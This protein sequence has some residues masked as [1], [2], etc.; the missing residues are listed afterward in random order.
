MSGKSHAAGVIPP[1]LLVQLYEAGDLDTYVSRVLSLLPQ[2]V[3]SEVTS[4]NEVNPGRGRVIWKVEPPGAEF[5]EARDVFTA[6]MAKHPL[7][8]HYYRTGD[9]RVLKLSDFVS[10]RQLRSLGIYQDCYRLIGVD[11]Q[12]AVTVPGPRSLVVG[13][14]VNR[15]GRDFSQAD[16]AVLTQ[17]RPHLVRA[18][19]NTAM[20]VSLRSQ[21]RARSVA[22]DALEEGLA[23]VDRQGRLAYLNPPARE[24]LLRIAAA[25]AQSRSLPRELCRLVEQ[26]PSRPGPSLCGPGGALEVRVLPG[27]GEKDTVV[28]LRGPSAGTG[29]LVARAKEMGLTPGRRRS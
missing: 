20:F 15:G 24:L 5:P 4:Y 17:L 1:E 6:H 11:R 26:L 29:V 10:L 19:A 12:L 7:I 28:V 21:L 9:S 14:T 3:G 22:L 18:Y 23:V 27:G 2:V 13:I 16:R 25:R 8:S